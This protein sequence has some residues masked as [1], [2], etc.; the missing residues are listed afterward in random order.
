MKHQSTC[1]DGVRVCAIGVACASVCACSEQVFVRVCVVGTI[2]GW[3][4]ACMW[5]SERVLGEEGKEQTGLV[6]EQQAAP[7]RLVRLVLQHRTNHHRRPLQI[8]STHPALSTTHLAFS[9]RP[10]RFSFFTFA[11][12][13]LFFYLSVSLTLS[14]APTAIFFVLW[15]VFFWF[16]LSLPLPSKYF[17]VPN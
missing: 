16:T 3:W 6:G 4:S 9:L 11:N 5:A 15:R 7:P 8:I 1:D 14:Q 12:S 2:V 13:S 17:F 10:F